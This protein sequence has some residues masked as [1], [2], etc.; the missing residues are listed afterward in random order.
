[1]SMETEISTESLTGDESTA[2][3]TYMAIGRI[4]F[5]QGCQNEDIPCWPLDIGYLQFLTVW[6]S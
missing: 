5:L 1:M 6:I 3:P 2:N 4:Q